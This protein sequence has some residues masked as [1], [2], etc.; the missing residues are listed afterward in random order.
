M[1]TE[2]NKEKFHR[3]L[4]FL[5]VSS[6][7]TEVVAVVIN[8]GRKAHYDSG[9]RVRN[10]W[11]VLTICGSLVSLSAS[12]VGSALQFGWRRHEPPLE[13]DAVRTI[14]LSHFSVVEY[15]FSKRIQTGRASVYSV[16]AELAQKSIAMKCLAYLMQFDTDE[17]D[18]KGMKGRQDV[19]LASYAAQYWVLHFQQ[20]DP[21]ARRPLQGLV[22]GFFHPPRQ[23]HFL[24]WVRM[25][26]LDRYPRNVIV[27][28]TLFLT[29]CTIRAV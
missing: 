21:D 16:N 24:N 14:R 1:H 12:L 3:I 13:T 8:P 6:E 7:L 18:E 4:Q 20:L 25:Y 15:L 26:N 17:L 23:K 22:Q 27:K 10:P 5:C 9:N 19:S 29:F 11:D 28:L 2:N